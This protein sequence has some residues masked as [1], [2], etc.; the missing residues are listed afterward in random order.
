MGDGI[1]VD[2]VSFHIA[3]NG[4]LTSNI[5]FDI[6]GRGTL[7]LQQLGSTVV[8][9]HIDEIHFED[10]TVIKI[11]EMDATY[12]GTNEDDYLNPN[13]LFTAGTMTVNGYGGNDVITAGYGTQYIIDG[14]SWR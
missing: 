6:S 14:W 12:H 7:T 4:L 2:G 1:S 11:K 9:E 10:S 13:F 8:S 3:L 5:F